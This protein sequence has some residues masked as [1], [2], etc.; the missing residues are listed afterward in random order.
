MDVV[1]RPAQAAVQRNPTD[2]FEVTKGRQLAQRAHR[3]HGLSTRNEIANE[4]FAGCWINAV[5]AAQSFLCWT[6]AFVGAKLRAG[7]EETIL[8]NTRHVRHVI[9]DR[10]VEIEMSCVGSISKDGVQ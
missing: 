7:K 4:E 9:G 8:L 6:R 1:V 3:R 5:Q 10:R 2:I